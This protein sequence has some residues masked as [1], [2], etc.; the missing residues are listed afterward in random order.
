[1]KQ[2]NIVKILAVCVVCLA[3]VIVVGVASHDDQLN[4]KLQT[5]LNHEATMD[6]QNK[7]HE[8]VINDQNNKLTEHAIDTGTMLVIDNDTVVVQPYGNV[9]AKRKKGDE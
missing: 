5:I 6:E 7:A 8:A 2:P 1:M 9:L 4:S 3:F